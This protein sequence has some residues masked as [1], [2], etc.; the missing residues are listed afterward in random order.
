MAY[1][2]P[3]SCISQPG[4][5]KRAAFLD[6]LLSMTFKDAGSTVNALTEED[7]QHEVDT[8][9]FEGHDTTA[10]A[11]TWF[12]LLIANHQEVRRKI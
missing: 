5:K 6:L 10:A 1:P 4:R 8:F 9:M 11:L 2:K 3:F 12:I 7:I